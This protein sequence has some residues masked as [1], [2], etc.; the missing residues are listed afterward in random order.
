MT[1]KKDVKPTFEIDLTPYKVVTIRDIAN[2][3]KDA[4][5]QADVK[6]K[7]SAFA[8][9]DVFIST[10]NMLCAEVSNIAIRNALA[11]GKYQVDDQE[12]LVYALSEDI[13]AHV[14]A[15]VR[16][17]NELMSGVTNRDEFMKR[18]EECGKEAMPHENLH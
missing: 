11:R 12:E 5:I 1:E 2:I 6:E 17:Y 3:I 14:N 4:L 7:N 9:Q 18:M 10:L 8:H 15:R 13:K 16:K